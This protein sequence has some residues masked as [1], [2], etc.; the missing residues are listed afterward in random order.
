MPCV[1]SARRPGK[2]HRWRARIGMVKCRGSWDAELKALMGGTLAGTYGGGGDAAVRGA[3]EQATQERTLASQERTVAVV[4]RATRALSALG[5]DRRAW[6]LRKEAERCK[7]RE[8]AAEAVRRQAEALA[9]A[10]V[11]GTCSGAPQQPV[12]ARI[13]IDRTRIRGERAA[14]S[15]KRAR[16]AATAAAMV[17]L[18][19]G[20]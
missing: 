11:A 15:R 16:R 19:K 5:G 14:A 8:A 9:T 20:E 1:G 3:A 2:W 7:A 17:R 18:R 4:G 13:V 10:I 6:Q 12:G